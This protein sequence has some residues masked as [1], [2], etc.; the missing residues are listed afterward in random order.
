MF[1]ELCVCVDQCLCESL[2]KISASYKVTMSLQKTW[3]QSLKEL[4]C[5]VF[6]NSLKVDRLVESKITF[7]TEPKVFLSAGILQAVSKED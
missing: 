5:N 3:I 4:F 1:D 6:M 7:V 2:N